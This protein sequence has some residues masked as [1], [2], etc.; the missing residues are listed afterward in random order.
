[1]LTHDGFNNCRFTTEAVYCVEIEDEAAP[2]VRNT[3][4]VDGYNPTR[5]VLINLHNICEWGTPNHLLYDSTTDK[6]S[7]HIIAISNNLLIGGA[8]QH[9]SP[10]Q[11]QSPHKSQ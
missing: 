4:H 11:H 6:T 10:Q 3:H 2:M 8:L 9:K 1:M 7:K 5:K